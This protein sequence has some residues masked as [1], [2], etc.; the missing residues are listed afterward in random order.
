[1]AGGLGTRLL[2]YTFFVPKPMLPLGDK[3]ILEHIIE[4]LKKFGI[5]DFILSVQYLS[6]VIEDYFGDGSN[7]NVNIV[8]VKSSRPMGTAGQLK[9][10]EPFLKDT[11]IC[12]YGDSI[13]DFDVKKVI[14][15]HKELKGIATMVLFNYSFKLK[16]GFIKIKDNRV[17]SWKEKPKVK[18]LINSGFYVFEPSF[19]QYIPKDKVYGM[20]SAFKEAIKRGEKISAYIAEGEFIDIGDKKAYSTAYKKY[21]EKLGKIP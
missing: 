3:P 17:V 6:R 14:K 7:F 10:A 1:L 20:D 11:F 2:P 9:V 15:F 19:L 4:W 16:Y 18:G 13:F 12:V 21:L 8:Y 5:K